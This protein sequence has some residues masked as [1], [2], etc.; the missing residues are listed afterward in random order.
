LPNITNFLISVDAGSES[1]YTNVRRGGKWSVLLENFDYLDSIG[2]NDKVQLN[3][4]VQKNNFY[5]L[6]NFVA[7]C[8]KYRFIANIHQLDDWGTWAKTM[9]V[10]P[11]SWTIVNGTFN[12][13]NVLNPQHINYA[14][15]KNILNRIAMLSGKIQ[16]SSNILSKMS[17]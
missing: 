9:P 3:F 15:C 5:D 8:Q 14:E 17:M 13:N 16:F 12:Q 6:E 4:A 11:D 1:V 10:N 7:L 2:V